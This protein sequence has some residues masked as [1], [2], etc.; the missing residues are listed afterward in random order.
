MSG[1]LTAMVLDDVAE[2]MV[3]SIEHVRAEFAGVRTGR[4]APA[5]VENLQVDYFGSIVPLK[6]LAG[7]SVPDARMLVI[8]PY[9]KGSLNVIEKAITSSD[10]GVSPSNDGNVIRISFPPLTED[11]RKEFVKVVKNKAEE[12]RV[13]VRNLRRAARQELEA[14]EKDW[15]RERSPSHELGGSDDFG[16]HTCWRPAR[17]RRCFFRSLAC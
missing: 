8:S 9:D 17:R 1:E 16:C 14:L 7:F 10:M 12:G 13:Q 5:L 4:A 3:K 6:Q 15:G 2:K 11:R